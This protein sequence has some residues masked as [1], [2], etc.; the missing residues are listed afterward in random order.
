MFENVDLEDSWVLNWHVNTERQ[1]LI[2]DLEA[3]LWEGHQY[4]TAP[5]PEEYTCYKN[6]QLIFDNV[7]NIDGL[8]S[9]ENVKPTVDSDGSTDYG[10]IEGLRQGEKGI[11]KLDGEFGEV[12]VAC[13]DIRLEFINH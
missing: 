13:K 9:M 11:Y 7:S 6:A 2:F 1:Q 10:N 3:S 4:Y 8:L 5:L 12:T